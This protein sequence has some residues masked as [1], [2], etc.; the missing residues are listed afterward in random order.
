VILDAI[1]EAGEGFIALASIP[2]P[3]GVIRLASPTTTEEYARILYAALRLGDAQGVKTIVVVPP[4][5]DGLA[6][7]IR[8]RLVRASRGR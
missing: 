6:V 2:T 7:A 3:A 4:D 5:G 1:A 8:D